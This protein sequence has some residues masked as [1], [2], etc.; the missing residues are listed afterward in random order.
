MAAKE[1]EKVF[2]PLNNVAEDFQ[3]DELDLDGLDSQKLPESPDI[4]APFAGVNE[5]FTDYDFGI[6]EPVPQVPAQKDHASD[7]IVNDFEMSDSAHLVLDQQ[8]HADPISADTQVLES[9][10]QVLPQEDLDV[11]DEFS[12]MFG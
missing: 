1:L 4:T 5:S 9:A 12:S 2:K 6:Y 3:E 7:S 10:P 11:L 8:D